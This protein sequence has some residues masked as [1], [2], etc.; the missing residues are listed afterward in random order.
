MAQVNR[1]RE[2]LFEKGLKYAEISRVT[3]FD[4][5]TVKKYIEQEDFNQAPKIPKPRS[6]KLDPYK[7]YIDTWLEEDKVARKKQRHTARRIYDRLVENYPEFD[8]SYRLVAS[9]VAE[10][11]QE[12]YG[13]SR[14]YVPLKHIP[15]EAQVVFYRYITEKLASYVNAGVLMPKSKDDLAFI[16]HSLFWLATNGT[17]AIVCFPGAMVS[18]KVEQKIRKYLIDV[19]FYLNT[20]GV[21]EDHKRNWLT[22]NI[23]FVTISWDGFEAIQNRSCPHLTSSTHSGRITSKYTKSRNMSD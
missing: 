14:F 10:K 16:M 4:V 22:D 8:C 23:D 15:R 5:K 6:S 12:L 7:N 11:R 3:G 21:M 1:I 9:Y 2:L 20:N 17:A 13:E 19:K 18:R